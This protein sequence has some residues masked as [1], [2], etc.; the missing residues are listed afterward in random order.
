MQP[1]EVTATFA[2]TRLLQALT[3][4][5]PRVRVAEGVANFVAWY[6]DYYGG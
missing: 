3:G 1:G 4:F 6:R 2:N 5:Q